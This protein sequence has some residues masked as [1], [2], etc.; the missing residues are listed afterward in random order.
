MLFR[1]LFSS[2]ILIVISMLMYEGSPIDGVT[3]ASKLSKKIRKAEKELHKKKKKDYLLQYGQPAVELEW[4]GQMRII[5]KK[6]DEN[7]Q[8]VTFVLSRLDEKGEKIVPLPYPP[9]PLQSL[10]IELSG[11]TGLLMKFEPQEYAVS[12]SFINDSDQVAVTVRAV[13]RVS[14]RDSLSNYMIKHTAPYDELWVGWPKRTEE[15]MKKMDLLMSQPHLVLFAMGGAVPAFSGLI[16][17]LVNHHYPGTISLILT[18]KCLQTI[19]NYQQLEK[20]KSEGK[21][22]L[23]I[24]L[25]QVGVGEKSEEWEKGSDT[26]YGR[27][28]TPDVFKKIGAFI[29]EGTP[30][31]LYL[32]SDQFE[33]EMKKLF[34][35]VN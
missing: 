13:P 30:Y 5:E 4:E 24:S 35:N 27:L 14:A 22:K 33:T 9:L 32:G 21:I 16:S 34:P 11:Y 25:T 7:S 3:G 31:Y 18:E 2:L 15:Q 29:G 26:A 19:P 12:D 6:V 8:T 23:F 20:W 17:W 10:H 1:V 28:T